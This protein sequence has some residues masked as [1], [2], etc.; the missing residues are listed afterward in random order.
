MTSEV[1]TA[2]PKSKANKK[3]TTTEVV[4]PKAD[5]I[6]VKAVGSHAYYEA[7]RRDADPEKFRNILSVRGPLWGHRKKARS[8]NG[9]TSATK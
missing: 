2:K 3:G 4:K 7:R 8:R 1:K 5:P 6:F 9:W